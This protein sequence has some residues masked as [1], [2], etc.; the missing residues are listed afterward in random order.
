MEQIVG[1]QGPNDRGQSNMTQKG[2][3]KGGVLSE[4]FNFDAVS[5]SDFRA[6]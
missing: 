3:E 4:L 6:I 2:E 5:N 1:S